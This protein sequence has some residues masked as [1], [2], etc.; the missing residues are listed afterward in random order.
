[1]QNAKANEIV[2]LELNNG[3]VE[4]RR[5]IDGGYGFQGWTVEEILIDV[6]GMSDTRTEAYKKTLFEFEE[7]IEAD[8]SQAAHIAFEKLD[9]L[10][11]PNNHLRKLLRLD[12]ASIAGAS[13]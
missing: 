1:M 8:N 12:L 10:L 9:K 3:I 6:M 13:E 5:S 4:R 11:H 7:A 2:A